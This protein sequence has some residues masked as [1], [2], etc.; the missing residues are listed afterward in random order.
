MLVSLPLVADDVAQY[1]RVVQARLFRRQPRADEAAWAAADGW[2]NTTVASRPPVTVP[3]LSLRARVGDSVVVGPSRQRQQNLP[4][5]MRWIRAVAANPPVLMDKSR[6]G[7][8]VWAHL[9]TWPS[10][11]LPSPPPLHPEP[12]AEGERMKKERARGHLS[13]RRACLPASLS[14]SKR[15]RMSRSRCCGGSPPPLRRFWSNWS[16]TGCCR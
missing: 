9:A 8:I 1:T 12:I 5:S 11:P 2:D 16:T 10:S 6:E 14:G 4:H 13:H 3:H 15:C 7:A